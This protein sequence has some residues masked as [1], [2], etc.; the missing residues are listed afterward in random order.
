MDPDT[1]AE[2]IV[3]VVLEDL[4][5]RAGFDWWWDDIDEQTQNEIRDDLAGKIAPLLP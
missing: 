5:D 4:A 1:R 2:Q 3:K